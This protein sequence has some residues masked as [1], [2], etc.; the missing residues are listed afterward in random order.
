M[1]ESEFIKSVRMDDV[2]NA[3][4]I[5]SSYGEVWFFPGNN[6]D[7]GNLMVGDEFVAT[8]RTHTERYDG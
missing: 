7:L 1:A 8:I 4:E 3:L 6:G 2:R 5:L